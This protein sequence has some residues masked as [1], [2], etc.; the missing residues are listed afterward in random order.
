[1]PVGR[2]WRPGPT[3]THGVG[4]QQPRLPP[5]QQSQAAGGAGQVQPG[6]PQS[7]S[8][9]HSWNSFVEPV[10]QI[11][12]P[13]TT[14]CRYAPAMWPGTGGGPA[15]LGMMHSHV[16]MEPHSSVV[17]VVLEVVVVVVVEVVVVGAAVVV[18][19]AAVVVV[20]AAVVV[21]AAAVVVVAAAVV[22]VA[23]WVVVVAGAVVVVAAAVVV[24]AVG[25]YIHTPFGRQGLCAQDSVAEQRCPWV[26]LLQLAAVNWPHVGWPS[27]RKQQVLPVGLAAWA[28][29]FM[30]TNTIASSTLR[31]LRMTIPR[32]A[33]RMTASVR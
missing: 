31:T 9:V 14:V 27:S 12:G 3:V 17:V 32:S 8:T 19:G 22:V 18:V 15:E 29:A 25:E 1:M 4:A 24:V 7:E 23:A 5:G 20:A 16:D 11:F 21:V 26:C 6:E 10:S 28:V 33:F 30:G 13:A 2:G